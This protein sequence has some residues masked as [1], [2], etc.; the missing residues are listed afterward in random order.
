MEDCDAG[1][2]EDLRE[3]TEV[4]LERVDQRES[5]TPRQL[6]EGEFRVVRALAVELGVERVRGL[7]AEDVEDRLE[8]GLAGDDVVGH[9]QLSRGSARKRWAS[10]PRST[11]A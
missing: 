2:F 5:V 7:V 4:D 9:R 3:R 8:S 1:T 10:P 11:R 6:H